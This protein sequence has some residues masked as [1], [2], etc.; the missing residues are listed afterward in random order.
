MVTTAGGFA[1]KGKVVSAVIDKSKLE[2][3]DEDVILVE[4]FVAGETA[5]F[6]HLYSKYYE[7]VSA[8]T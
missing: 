3:F 6:E 4:R 2:T 1:S 7:K 5:A 8:I